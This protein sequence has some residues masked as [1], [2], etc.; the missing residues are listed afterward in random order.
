MNAAQRDD[1]HDERGSVGVEAVT[2]ARLQHPEGKGVRMEGHANIACLRQ[3][4]QP[5]NLADCADFCAIGLPWT[6]LQ[7]PAMEIRGGERGRQRKMGM[8]REEMGKEM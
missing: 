6:T 2:Q 8:W 1:G 5:Q 3:S 7:D 4:R